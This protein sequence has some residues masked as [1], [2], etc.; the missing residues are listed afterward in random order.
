MIH[1]FSQNLVS[2]AKCHVMLPVYRHCIKSFR[3]Q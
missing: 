1:V 2:I 3:L